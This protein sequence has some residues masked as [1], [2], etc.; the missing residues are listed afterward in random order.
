MVED[1][2]IP[3]TLL[4]LSGLSFERRRILDQE[5]LKKA[6]EIVRN[7]GGNGREVYI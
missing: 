6:Q 1:I 4:R 5:W 2:L 7:K 3:S